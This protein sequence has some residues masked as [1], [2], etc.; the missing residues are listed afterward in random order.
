MFQE[1]VAKFV[2]YGK[3]FTMNM[4]IRIEPYELVLDAH[5]RGEFVIN[6]GQGNHL[7]PEPMGNLLNRDW[8]PERPT[9]FLKIGQRA[10]SD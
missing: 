10:L 5:K 4:M 1:D 8:S 7:K 2:S 3:S 6:G 9:I